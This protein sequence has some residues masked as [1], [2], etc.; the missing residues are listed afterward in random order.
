MHFTS[1][2]SA[3]ALA[4]TTAAQS[5][6]LTQV[7]QF[8]NSF[9]GVGY[10]NIENIALRKSNGQLL[11]NTVTGANMAQLD[12]AN[13]QAELLVNLT[14]ALGNGQPG[15]LTGIA[16]TSH[17]VYTVAAGNFQFGPQ[18]PGG[19]LGVNGSFS[20]WNVDLN[21]S[22]AKTSLV[23]KIPE[24]RSLN[25]V[26]AIPKSDLVLIADSLLG[27]VYS[28]NIKTGEYKVVI[29][30]S[31]FLPNLGVVNFGI[32]GV[33][34]K[35]KY[36]YFTNSAQMIF[37]RVPIDLQSGKAVG[38]I[39]IVAK[40]PAAGAT[41]DDFDFKPSTGDAWIASQPTNVWQVTQQGQV[42]LA[43]NSTELL[44][45]TATAFGADGCT[46][47]VTTG[48]VGGGPSGPMSGQVFAVDT[49]GEQQG[50]N[51]GEKQWRKWR[52]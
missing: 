2:L 41:F 32:N 6:P 46:L 12:P 4:A 27:A 28:V 49:C 42:N 10:V 50:Q 25:G 21:G 40:G 5:Y 7:Y 43:V 45:P 52:A 20:V 51:Q 24:A 38:A 30:D 14:N 34:V 44:G 29:Q 23:T 17:D 35:G 9:S 8:E 18:V 15:S 11:L 1:L 22:P 19:V 36:L 31:L 3:A 26:T 48:G 47:Y 13:P 33:Q 37:G 16:E 39:E